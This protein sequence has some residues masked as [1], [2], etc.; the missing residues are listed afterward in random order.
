MPGSLFL[1]LGE[2]FFL[3]FRCHNA[4]EFLA[5]R[6][7]ALPLAGARAAIN[8]VAFV[9]IVFV[10]FN[11]DCAGAFQSRNHN[12]KNQL[13]K[14]ETGTVRNSSIEIPSLPTRR[15]LSGL[16]RFVNSV[17]PEADLLRPLF[18][19]IPMTLFPFCKTKSTS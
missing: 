8:N 13:N 9:A 18:T 11:T 17:M 3:F 10:F 16:N 5:P 2:Y 12:E 19:S 15:T 1:L 7:Y 6:A 14:S 4:I